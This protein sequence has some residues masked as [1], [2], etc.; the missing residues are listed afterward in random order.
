M[1][2]QKEVHSLNQFGQTS[3]KPV[4]LQCKWGIVPSKAI[5]MSK[6]AHNMCYKL[7]TGKYLDSIEDTGLETDHVQT[8]C[9]SNEHS[10]CPDSTDNSHTHIV[11]VHKEK[12]AVRTATCS[13]KQVAV[14]AANFSLQLSTV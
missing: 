12:L 6:L 13:T 9:S 10:Y 4:W 7:R 2:L 8:V 3:S 14:Q 5:S 11:F 1:H